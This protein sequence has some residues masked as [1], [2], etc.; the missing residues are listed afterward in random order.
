M[1]QQELSMGRADSGAVFSYL[2]AEGWFRGAAVLQTLMRDS[3]SRAVA[4]VVTFDAF[5]GWERGRWARM[6]R[7]RRVTGRF[8]L[9]DATGT[10]VAKDRATLERVLGWDG[11]LA[12]IEWTHELEVPCAF[13][14]HRLETEYVPLHQVVAVRGFECHLSDG[15]GGVE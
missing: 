3:R 8:E 13:L 14:V 10:P 15:T 4:N 7:R 2:H 9:L 11:N 12:S 5:E 1:Q 6:S